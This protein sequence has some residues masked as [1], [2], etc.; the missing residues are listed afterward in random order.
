MPVYEF[1]ATLQNKHD[2][3]CEITQVF[4]DFA[5]TEHE[6]RRR[7]IQKS[8]AAEFWVSLLISVE[9]LTSE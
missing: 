4:Q 5:R 7:I 6:A 3:R 1:C 9:D 8:L 2:P